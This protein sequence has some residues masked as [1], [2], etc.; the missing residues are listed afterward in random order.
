MKELT[1]GPRLASLIRACEK[2]CVVDCC[3]LDA[4][5]FS[6]LHAASHLSAFT[7]V[8]S[9]DDIAA[10]DSEVNQLVRCAEKCTPNSD[11]F[12]CSIAGTNQLFTMAAVREF[13]KDIRSAVRL[14]PKV[15]EFAERLSDGGT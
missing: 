14:A 4:F 8:I 9:D 12:V 10:I 5:D 11:D 6:P 2:V 1:P 7:G 15:L 3:G 13:A